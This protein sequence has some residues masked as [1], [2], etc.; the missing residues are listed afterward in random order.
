MGPALL[1]VAVFLND[2]VDY[3][4]LG[5]NI[6]KIIKDLIVNQLFERLLVHLLL[7]IEQPIHLINDILWQIYN[8]S[9]NIQE[10]LKNTQSS[11]DLQ[12]EV[13]SI[14]FSFLVLLKYEA[15]LSEKDEW[16]KELWLDFV[17]EVICFYLEETEDG[18]NLTNFNF[19]IQLN[20][21]KQPWDILLQ[22]K[23]YFNRVETCAMLLPT[24]H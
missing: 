13:A 1:E 24:I 6:P 8:S 18:H 20:Q 7:M 12:L 15:W 10:L 17:F 19:R 9:D 4:Q 23:F 16:I 21:V 11:T 2:E 14:I 22:I 5:K 3:I